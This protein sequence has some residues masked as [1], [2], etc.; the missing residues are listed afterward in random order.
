MY[1][2]KVIE[3]NIPYEYKDKNVSMNKVMKIKLIE[4]MDKKNYDFNYLNKIG[5]KMIRGPRKISKEIENKLK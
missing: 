1:K 4:K 2:C 5:I 3:V